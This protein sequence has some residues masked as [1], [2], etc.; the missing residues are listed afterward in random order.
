MENL[1][2]IQ[3]MYLES[4]NP[5]LTPFDNWAYQVELFYISAS[6]MKLLAL[7]EIILL[8]NHLCCIRSGKPS[9]YEPRVE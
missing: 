3:T 1:K 2:K 7:I 4:D 9:R 5:Y 6:L 8:S